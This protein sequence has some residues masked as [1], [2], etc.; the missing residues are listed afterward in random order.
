K[1]E[2]PDDSGLVRQDAS[3]NTRELSAIT[4]TNFQF[5]DDLSHATRRSRDSCSC[6]SLAMALHSAGQSDHSIVSGD[7]NVTA[8]HACV[9]MQ[10]IFHFRGYICIFYSVCNTAAA[11]GRSAITRLG[12][13]AT[14]I[15]RRNCWLIISYRCSRGGSRNLSV[16]IC[17]VL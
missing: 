8:L 4:V 5:V 11:I 12:A 6:Q 7:V 10:R 13:A 9:F 15:L 3:A 2:P 14:R 17:R 16:G 1:P